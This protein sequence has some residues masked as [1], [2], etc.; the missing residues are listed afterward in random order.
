MAQWLGAFPALEHGIVLI[1]C[2]KDKIT[3]RVL[4]DLDK[5]R[6]RSL[7]LWHLLMIVVLL[8][9]PTHSS[10]SIL[11]PVH[12]CSSILALSTAIGPDQVSLCSWGGE[13][14]GGFWKEES[15]L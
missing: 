3:S 2:R 13:V 8:L 1:S 9:E 12:D 6:S 10:P 4:S 5:A 14:K 15:K 11:V 7:C